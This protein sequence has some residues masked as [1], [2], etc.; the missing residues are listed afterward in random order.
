MIIQHMVYIPVL[1]IVAFYDYRYGIIPNK[2]TYPAAVLA[3]VFNII[4]PIMS[5]QALVSGGV[6]SLILGAIL[7]KQAGLGGGDIKLMIVI[8]LAYGMPLCL[9]V[10][11]GGFIFGGIATLLAT[12]IKKKTLKE[13]KPMPVGVFLALSGVIVSL[14]M[15]FISIILPAA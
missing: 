2:I 12:L 7:G 11:M 8:G 4:N 9:A 3:I 10:S 14:W 5:P 6:V 1:L 13:L 15:N